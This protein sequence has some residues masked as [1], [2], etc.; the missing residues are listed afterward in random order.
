M[1]C[2]IIHTWRCDPFLSTSHLTMCHD[3]F[4]GIL[5]GT[6]KAPC[7]IFQ[8]FEFWT[9]SNFILK[10]L[11]LTLRTA[12]SKSLLS[13]LTDFLACLTAFITA[14]KVGP[15][16]SFLMIFLD[17]LCLK[18]EK[19]LQVMFILVFHSL[20]LFL[21]FAIMAEKTRDAQ[22]YSVPVITMP[23]RIQL[24]AIHFKSNI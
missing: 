8:K 23:L 5:P 13:F 3:T 12:S 21:T 18:A 19:S 7:S 6:C 2:W 22:S 14:C 16:F 20:L 17:T 15:N 10:I 4:P 9:C 1:F 24:T 11:W